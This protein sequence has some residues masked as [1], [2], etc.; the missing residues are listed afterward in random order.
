MKSSYQQLYRS[1]MKELFI[2]NRL[3][4]KKEFFFSDDNKYKIKYKQLSYYTQSFQ[5]P[6]L[7]P[8]LEFKEYLPQF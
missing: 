7:Y 4:S 5:Q 2:Y 8:I 6:L 1:I 3:W